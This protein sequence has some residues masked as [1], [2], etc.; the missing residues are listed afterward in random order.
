[1]TR[2][3]TA[4]DPYIPAL[5]FRK[6]TP[7]YDPFLQWVMQEQRFK[8]RLVKQANVEHAQSVLDLG[9]GTGTLT[10]MLIQTYPNASLIGLDIDP[11]ILAIAQHKA[12]HLPIRWVC[13]AATNIPL[14]SHSLDR[15][16][17]SL[18]L[19]HLTPTNKKRA[20]AEIFRV[21]RPGGQLH[22]VDFGQPHS[23]YA[24][25]IAPLVRPFEEVASNLDG[26]LDTLFADACF[27]RINESA[28]ITTVA[29]DLYLYALEKPLS[30]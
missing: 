3:T 12:T 17:T 30:A 15:V 14:A 11:A 29:G 4:D 2:A 20:L 6:L 18:M 25:L 23:S 19:H 27:T 10:R 5:S 9:C 22:V 21:L 24:R 13:A 1:M 8:G 28:P 16:V 26:Y 7:F